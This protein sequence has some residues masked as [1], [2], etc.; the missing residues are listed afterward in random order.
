MKI[1]KW[2]LCKCLC[3]HVHFFTSWIILILLS[4]SSFSSFPPVPYILLCFQG[5]PPDPPADQHLQFSPPVQFPP[6][7][8]CQTL[9][10]RATLPSLSE[11]VSVPVLRD[12]MA[13]KWKDASLPC[14]KAL[15]DHWNLK[16]VKKVP[17]AKLDYMY[18]FLKAV[19]LST[20]TCLL[21]YFILFL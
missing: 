17:I 18:I 1:V 12:W 4:S 15:I 9:T 19:L 8:S 5:L 6:S 3:Q 21:F 16:K 11:T 2:S 13:L 20:F 10:S 14:L 7:M